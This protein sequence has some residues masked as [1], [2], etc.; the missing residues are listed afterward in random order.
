MK[1]VINVGLIGVGTVGTGVIKILNERSSEIERKV[2]RKVALKRVA[3][4]SLSN[5]EE[6][7]IDRPAFTR[8]AEDV[9]G[10]SEVDILVELIG[11]YEPARTL[12][13]EALDRGKQVVTANK[14]LLAKHGLEV[15]GRAIERGGS[16]YFEASVA[17]GI[18]VIKALRESLGADRI[19]SILGIVNGTSNFILA[20]MTH[21]KKDFA[22]VLSLAQEKGYAE[23]NPSFDVEGIDSA[24][25]LAILASLAFGVQ[26][27]LEDIYVEGITHITE[28]DI[29]YA[30]EMGYVVKLLAIAKEAD[31]EIE[32]RVNPTMIPQHNLLAAVDEAY[33][34]IYV[35]GDI[36][37]SLMFYGR[38]AGQMPASSAVASDIMDA[39]RNLHLCVKSQNLAYPRMSGGGRVKRIEEVE[40]GYYIRFS[41]IDKPGVLAAISG[42]FGQHNISIASVVQKERRKEATVPLLIITHKANEGNMR[43]AINEIDKLA[44][45]TDKSILIRVERED[46]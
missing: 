34:A 4:R 30:G 11:G 1:D 35:V 40:S 13:L 6:V 25:K 2:G 41:V 22:E 19:T 29:Q 27:R 8:R 3:D 21:R 38:G 9:V 12:V 33:N 45:V 31:G 5:P 32:V 28:I 17:S 7:G 39:A 10:D 44:V 26:V 43:R 18:P 37:G 16:I 14:A 24:H 15:F 23:A 36:A 20:E 42:I 46:E